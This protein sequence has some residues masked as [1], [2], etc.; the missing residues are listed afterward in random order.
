MSNTSQSYAN[1]VRWHTPHHFIV[2]PVLIINVVWAAVYFYLYPTWNQGWWIIVSAA[3]V[4][5]GVITRINSLRVQDR[6][7]RLEEQVRYE[8]L[9]PADLAQRGALLPISQ[10]IALRFAS[11]AELSGLLREVLD[12]K[13]S[14]PAEIKRAI[15]NWRADQLRV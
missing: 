4:I 10:M 12:G 13:F 7:I 11:D 5:L 1:H 14:K 3:L 6:L 8:R 2:M 9:L 15:T